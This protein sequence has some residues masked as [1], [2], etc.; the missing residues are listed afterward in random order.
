M[1][2]YYKDFGAIRRRY[3]FIRD[4]HSFPGLA[5]TVRL[6]SLN[7]LVGVYNHDDLTYDWYRHDEHLGYLQTGS[8][9]T[10]PE[11][12]HVIGAEHGENRA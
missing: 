7:D 5:H 1:A 12:A 10:L 4:E 2:R 6:Y 9:M 3:Q 11:D 8:T